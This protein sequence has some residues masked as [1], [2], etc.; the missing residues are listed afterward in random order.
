MPAPSPSVARAVAAVLL[1]QILVL[2]ALTAGAGFSAAPYLGVVRLCGIVFCGLAMVYLMASETAGAWWSAIVVAGSSPLFA[3]LVVTF[4]LP[5]PGAA[6]PLWVRAA[7]SCASV[8]GTLVVLIGV[9]ALVTR[10]RSDADRP[11]GRYLGAE[12]GQ[13]RSPP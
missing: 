12:R 13:F 4:E 9:W 10:G 11:R 8:L 6:V 1:A 3:L 7:T 2:A 5:V